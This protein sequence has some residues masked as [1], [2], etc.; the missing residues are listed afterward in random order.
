MTL[1]KEANTDSLTQ[2]FNRRYM[3]KQLAEEFNQAIVDGKELCVALVDLDHFGD[4][5]KVHGW[6]TGDKALC[7]AAETITKSI[8]AADW[9]G[10]YGGE[11]ICI[12]MPGISLDQAKLICERARIA[13]ES[14]PCATTSDQPLRI[15]VSIGVVELDPT[16]DQSVTQL[17]ER[18]SQLT[19]KAKNMGRNQVQS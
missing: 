3:D 9:V 11:E 15:T 5:N 1:H 7:S 10:R 13:I 6:P 8:R 16:S 19:L 2:L 14:N 18:V 12:V 4:V 17:I